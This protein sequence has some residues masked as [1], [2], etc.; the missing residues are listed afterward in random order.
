MYKLRISVIFC[1]IVIIVQ[2]TGVELFDSDSE[3]TEAW[4]NFNLLTFI[5]LN[6]RRLTA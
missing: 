1:A 3:L 6:S 5:K 2:L 4:L